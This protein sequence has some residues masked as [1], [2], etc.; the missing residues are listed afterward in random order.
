[1]SKKSVSNTI[2]LLVI[3][4]CMFATYMNYKQEKK[5]EHKELQEKVRWMQTQDVVSIHH[6]DTLQVATVE[7]DT[8]DLSSLAREGRRIGIYAHRSQCSD[9]WRAVVRNMRNI[10]KAYHIEEPFVLADG[11]R[12][13]DVRVMEKEDSIGVPIYTLLDN[14]DLYIHDLSLAGK[15][16][17]FLLNP[18][19]TMSSVICYNDV[20]VPEMMEYFK[21]LSVDSMYTGEVHV[22]PSCVKLGKIP[23]RREFK[24]HFSMKN[25][26]QKVCNITRIEPSCTCVQI[27]K[28]P[29]CILPGKTVEI[30]MVF[31][32]DM[33]G[34]FM[35][36]IEV[37]TDF[38]D[39]PYILS[40]EGNCQ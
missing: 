34:P 3:L 28:V 7:R 40:I 30:N 31:F 37:Y 6:I 39:E 5:R 1:M 35:R 20:I 32:S 2:F 18:N 15:P 14:E 16:F 26:S 4:L 22:T 9:C 24:L 29:D 21:T 8:I 13:I 23:H 11:F 10:C 38:R 17:V 36:E 33:L 19:A 12:T 25:A 27:E